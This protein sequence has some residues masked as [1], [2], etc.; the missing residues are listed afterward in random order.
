MGEV[1]GLQLPQGSQIVARSPVSP[2]RGKGV[3]MDEVLKE[4]YEGGEEWLG[5]GS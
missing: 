5:R 4:V 1:R 3:E 2:G